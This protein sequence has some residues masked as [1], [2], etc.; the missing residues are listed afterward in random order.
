VTA[1]G[2]YAAFEEKLK[3]S[4][5]PGQLADLVVLAQ[6]PFKANPSELLNIKVERT[7]IGGDF[8]LYLTLVTPIHTKKLNI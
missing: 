4:I 8:T 5:Q 3:G 1:I 2:A 6:D 7:M